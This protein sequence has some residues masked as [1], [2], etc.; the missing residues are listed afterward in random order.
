MIVDYE[1]IK[2]DLNYN[3]GKNSD[4]TQQLN[5][6]VAGRRKAEDELFRL[7][8]DYEDLKN[9]QRE[10]QAGDSREIV[11]LNCKISELQRKLDAAESDNRKNLEQLGCSHKDVT[12]WKDIAESYQAE[13]KNSRE[14]VED[15]E[16]KNRLLVDKLNA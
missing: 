15:L 6:N 16:M 3:A 5:A 9:M 11:N 1:K 12:Y 8:K 4:L 2:H 7:A 14:N 13:I 10:T